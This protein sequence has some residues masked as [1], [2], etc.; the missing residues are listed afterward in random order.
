MSLYVTDT[1]ALIWYAQGRSRKLGRRARAAFE[2]AESGASVIYVPVLSLVELL[3][4]VQ[5]GVLRLNAAPREWVRA[6][7]STG[8]FLQAP[9]TAEIAVSAAEL[10]GIPER[11]DRLIAATAVT[12]GLPLITRDATIAQAAGVAVIW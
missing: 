12:L 5:R 2:Q 9:L 8:A 6:L 1:H 3:E 4:A 11:G 10:T 7:F